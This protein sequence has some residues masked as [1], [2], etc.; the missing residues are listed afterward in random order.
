[1]ALFAEGEQRMSIPKS[2]SLR[3][4]EYRARQLEL[5]KATEKLSILEWIES[6]TGPVPSASEIEANRALF[7]HGDNRYSMVRWF[8]TAASENARKEFCAGFGMNWPTVDGWNRKLL[9]YMD[10]NVRTSRAEKSIEEQSMKALERRERKA[11]RLLKQQPG[12][13]HPLK[14]K[15]RSPETLAKI[16]KTRSDN[17]AAGMKR[18]G[19]TVEM[20]AR[21]TMTAETKQ[22]ISNGL[23][24]SYANGTRRSTKGCKLTMAREVRKAVAA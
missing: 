18:A 7:R 22:A 11:A 6:Q 14:G 19:R 21:S 9:A 15:K 8:Y 10:P 24:E 20:F 16:A 12:Y 3:G 13:I 23:K 4:E 5:R 2:A 1:M 17:K